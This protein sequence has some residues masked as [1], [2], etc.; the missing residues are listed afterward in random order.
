MTDKDIA[1]V[2]NLNTTAN[3]EETRMWVI[4]L[5]ATVIT[6]SELA[7]PVIKLILWVAAIL[8]MIVSW[9]Q[10]KLLEEFT[11]LMKCKYCDENTEEGE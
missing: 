8:Q 2:I 11:N 6:E 7:P 5:L 4:I 3:A 10:R 1:T 9:M